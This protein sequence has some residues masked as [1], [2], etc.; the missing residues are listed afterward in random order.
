VS[1]IPSNSTYCLYSV[2]ERF[3]QETFGEELWTRALDEAGLND[4]LSGQWVSTC[5]YYDHILY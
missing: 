1:A 4:F 2:A 5:P 3:V